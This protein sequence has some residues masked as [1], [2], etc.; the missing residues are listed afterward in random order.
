MAP[1]FGFL[2]DQYIGQHENQIKIYYVRRFSSEFEGQRM[3]S[4]DMK[5]LTPWFSRGGIRP[6][7]FSENAEKNQQGYKP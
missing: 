5:G 7:L 6:L 2:I 1:N 3:V 4:S